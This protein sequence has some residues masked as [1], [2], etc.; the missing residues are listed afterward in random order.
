MQLHKELVEII[1][2]DLNKLQDTFNTI[3]C[4]RNKQMS[5]ASEWFTKH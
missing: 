2:E 4:H 5:D 3:S 1:S